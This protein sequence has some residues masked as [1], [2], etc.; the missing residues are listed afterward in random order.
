MCVCICV[1]VYVGVCV[2]LSEWMNER[3]R[4]REREEI[5]ASNR[6]PK[7]LT[8][9]FFSFF[10]RD[11]FPFHRSMFAI[12]PDDPSTFRVLSVKFFALLFAS[13]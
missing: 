5:E 6:C 12:D 9:M 10:L 8:I 2:R 7:L 3:E 4:E 11:A 1:C 13:S